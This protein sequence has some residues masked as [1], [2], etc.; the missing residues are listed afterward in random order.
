[1]FRE[2]RGARGLRPLVGGASFLTIYLLI[3]SYQANG[4]MKELL[5]GK[6]RATA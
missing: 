6:V 5:L 1:V 4:N 3:L 2:R